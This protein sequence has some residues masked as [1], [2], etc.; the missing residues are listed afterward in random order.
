MGQP[1]MGSHKVEKAAF[2]FKG[3][4]SEAGKW[5]L[6]FKKKSGI[7]QRWVIRVLLNVWEECQ[8]LFESALGDDAEIV[9]ADNSVFAV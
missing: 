1:F 9:A 8:T 7:K 5:E 2:P 3:G 6:L 4:E